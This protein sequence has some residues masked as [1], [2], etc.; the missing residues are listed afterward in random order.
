MKKEKLI[1]VPDTKQE[2]IKKSLSILVVDDEDAILDMLNKFLSRKGH[3]VKTVNNG[4]DAI[5]MIEGEEFDLVLTDMDMPN[6]T[7]HDVIK[8]ANEL[9]KRP[10]IGI[11]TGSDKILKL[12]VDGNSKVDFI[13]MKPFKLPELAKHINDLFSAGSK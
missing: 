10:K 4:A 2:T 5:N 13:L 7:G 12:V 6:V 9:E 11:I 3:N 8:V 1:T